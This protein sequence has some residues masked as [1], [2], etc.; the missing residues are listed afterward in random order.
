MFCVS[1]FHRRIVEED[2][3]GAVCALEAFVHMYRML[4][5]FTSEHA[6]IM[7]S[8]RDHVTAFINEQTAREK[9]V[10]QTHD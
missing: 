3:A 8:A 7:S 9:E 4:L 1:V 2:N 5:S 10:S 6:E